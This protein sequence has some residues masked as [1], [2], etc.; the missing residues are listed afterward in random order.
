MDA[1][2]AEQFTTL[3]EDRPLLVQ[4]CANDPALL[5]KAA[6][7]VRLLLVSLPHAARVCHRVCRCA[8]TPPA[9]TCHSTLQGHLTHTLHPCAAWQAAPQVDGID[10]NL[11][12]PQRIARW[13]P[14]L[15]LSLLSVVLSSVPDQDRQKQAPGSPQGSQQECSGSSCGAQ[16]S[17]PYRS[18]LLS[19]LRV[20]VCSY[21]EF[22][23]SRLGSTIL[24]YGILDCLKIVFA[25]LGSRGLA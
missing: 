9:P 23:R 10:L 24:N 21:K 11:G 20:R 8:Y 1:C 3:P 5:V 7:I 14:F 13:G 16:T 25:K 12:C 2:R 19:W 18:L 17:M 15:S 4:F 6:R 22:N